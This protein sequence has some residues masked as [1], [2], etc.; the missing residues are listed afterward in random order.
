NVPADLIDPRIRD[1]ILVE[2]KHADRLAGW[3]IACNH[4]TPPGFVT[5]W[6][7][8][9]FTTIEANLILTAGSI[10][11]TQLHNTRLL[12]QKEQ[13]FTDVVCAM[14]NA[15]E[16]RDDYTCG[17]SERVALFAQ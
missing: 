7:Q 13:L 5:H 11:A 4:V 10:L 8:S 9:G 1:F 14:V 16:A 17:H 12:R 6:A 3:L 15:V 2:I